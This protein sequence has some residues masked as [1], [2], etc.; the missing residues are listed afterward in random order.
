MGTYTANYQLYMPTVGEQG[1]GDLM[2]GNLTTIDTTMAGLNTR[3]TAV[4]S[5]VNGNLSCTSVTTSGTITSTGVINANGGVIGVLYVQGV[6]GTSG[7]ED[8]ATL[9]KQTL[10]ITGVGAANAQS[11]TCNNYDI[12]YTIPKIHCAGVYTRA[13]DLTGTLN[14]SVSTRKLNII[15]NN[16]TSGTG[17]AAGYRYLYYKTSTDAKY[18]ELYVSFTGI[19]AW[20]S[21]IVLSLDVPVGTTYQFYSNVYYS[22]YRIFAEYAEGTTYKVKYAT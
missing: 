9:A 20:S 10:E 16:Y 8:Y 18:T 3:L 17:T 2:N 6:V 1:W 13:S 22:T 12:S 15:A 11:F 5:E 7:D 19:P 14:P 21:K 4:E